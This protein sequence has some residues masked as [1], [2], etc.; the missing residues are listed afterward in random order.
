MNPHPFRLIVSSYSLALAVALVLPNAGLVTQGVVVW[1]G[2]A[3]FVFVLAMTPGIRTWF[4]TD[5]DRPLP[6]PLGSTAMAE[7]NSEYRR[8][9]EDARIEALNHD[10]EKGIAGNAAEQSETPSRKTA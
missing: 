1:L 3:G 9:D 8:W 6:N 2:G 10:A 5:L 7:G 4:T